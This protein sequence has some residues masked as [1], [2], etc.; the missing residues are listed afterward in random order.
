MY[1]IS[2][3]QNNFILQKI[4]L[5]HEIKKRIKNESYN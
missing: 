2:N 3:I 4:A 5:L 1:D